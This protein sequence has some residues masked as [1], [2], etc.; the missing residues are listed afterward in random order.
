[1][2]VVR[3]TFYDAAESE[4]YEFEV[5]PREGGTPSYRKN[6]VYQNTLAPGGRTLIFEGA[7]EP[8]KLSWAGVIL[9]QEHHETFVD[10]YYKRHQ[11]LLTDDLSRQYTVYISAYEPKRER[12]ALHPW[13]HSY[14]MEATI[15]DWA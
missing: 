11:I 15:L 4:T 1:M 3:W 5:N 13:K 2:A 12:S 14:T 6:I 10:W 8:M 9:T 7:D